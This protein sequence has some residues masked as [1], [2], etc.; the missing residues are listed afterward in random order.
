MRTERLRVLVAD[1]DG[2]MLRAMVR[3]LGET[4]EI[5]GQVSTGRH[6]V[7]AALEL[8]P[9]VIVSDFSMPLMNGV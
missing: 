6:L 3:L 5:V 7:N 9:D 2:L 4:F 8:R 1:D